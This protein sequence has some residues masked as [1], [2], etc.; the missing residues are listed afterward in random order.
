MHVAEHQVDT[1]LQRQHGLFGLGRVGCG[2]DLVAPLEQQP[3]QA[4]ADG[5]FVVDDQHHARRLDRHRLRVRGSRFFLNA[6]QTAECD[7]DTEHRPAPGY[8]RHFEPVAQQPHQPPHDGQA[9]AEALSPVA[10]VAPAGTALVELLKD[11]RQLF[12]GDTHP[13]V[14]DLDVDVRDGAARHHHCATLGGV[15]QR[16]LHQVADD[17][18]QQLRVAGDGFATGRKT[19]AQPGQFGLAGVL[20]LQAPE[21]VAQREG[22]QPRGE[23]GAV[24]PRNVEQRA[25]RPFEVVH[26]M[27]KVAHQRLVGRVLQPLAQRSGEQAQGMHRLAQVV[28]GDGQEAALLFTGAQG[29]V[30][31]GFDTAHACF[32]RQKTTLAALPQPVPHQGH[33][34][35]T[36]G[37]DHARQ[38]PE[39]H[40]FG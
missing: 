18:F 4:L 26:R 29:D 9:H 5:L 35:G 31:F 19:Q 33:G 30:A 16:V 40:R 38:Q 12:G 2:D 34:A 28:A 6:R 21:Q 11:P 3:A 1:A 27:Q 39:Q 37:A 13:G 7:A 24:Q 22:V 23:R 14:P 10:P 15:A 8:R 32:Q 20:H 25:E 36:R 17:P